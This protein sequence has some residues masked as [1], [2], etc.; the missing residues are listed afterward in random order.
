MSISDISLNNNSVSTA[1]G[2]SII[3]LPKEITIEWICRYL[4][5]RDTVQLA[6]T[7]RSLCF[8]ASNSPFAAS[9]W[10]LFLR[11]DFPGSYKAFKSETENFSLYKRLK[12]AMDNMKAGNYRPQILNG[13]L[14]AIECVKV[15]NDM[16]ISGGYDSTIKIW[17]LNAGRELLT[18][19][20]YLGSVTCLEILNGMLISGST[21]NTIKIWDLNTGRELWTL[22][23]HQGR[24]T[25]L[26]ILD[27]KLISGSADGTIKIWNPST[28][29]LLQTLS[30]HQNLI[31]CM[32][33]LDGKLISG[34]DDK[35]IKVWDLN[36]GQPT[37]TLSG[38]Q[39]MI[40]CMKILDGK[41]ISGSADG[42]IKIWDLSTGQLLQTLSGYQTSIMC[43]KILDGR[44]ISG[45]VDETIKI[46]D[47]STGQLLQ[48]LSGHQSR[49]TCMRTLG[50]MLISG[51][52]DETIKIWDLSTGQ[53]LQTISGHEDD[54]D[55]DAIK[56]MEIQDGKFVSSSSD[57]ML[58]KK[59]TIKI[60]DFNLPSLPPAVREVSQHHLEVLEQTPHAEPMNPSILQCL[61]II[62]ETDYSEQLGTRPDHLALRGIVTLKDL[63]IICPPSLEIQELSIDLLPASA[64]SD[65]RAQQVNV[66]R[67]R[68]E[69]SKLCHQ[70]LNAITAMEK[71]AKTCGQVL[72]EGNAPWKEL[73]LELIAFNDELSAIKEKCN[74]NPHKIIEAFSGDSYVALA[75]PLNK[76]I[77]KFHEVDR[78][79]R[80]VKLRAYIHQ[81]LPLVVWG[82]LKDQGI[83]TLSGF[84]ERFPCS[85]WELFHMKASL[86]NHGI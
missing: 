36:T 58:R 19:N 9:L 29:Q 40:T 61:G 44:L 51:S 5:S 73:Q 70:M 50:G 22:S 8:L 79:H 24:I 62:T 53:L 77:R 49:I 46:W 43:M 12:I 13:H 6:L 3:E 38:H 4:N 33:I 54:G 14:G 81:E 48:T 30:G 37:K 86:E 75:T 82:I 72:Y 74:G 7:H 23:E 45:S 42:T 41:L 69:L 63:N 84:Q 47:L 1:T 28:G 71:E 26:K 52:D 27:G 57:C 78:L 59:S 31:R 20:G 17:D 56:W 21:D 67:N 25:C 10:N 18:V 60:W 16:L 85:L 76:F 34:S 11:K 68:L 32:K 15:L 83:S 39:R 66:N 55:E 80:I 35:T 65:F 2:T 64:S